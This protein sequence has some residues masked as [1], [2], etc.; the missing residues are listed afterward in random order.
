M[1]MLRGGRDGEEK[2]RTSKPLPY[3]KWM[4]FA[5]DQIEQKVLGRRTRVFDV[6]YN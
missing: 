5:E 4:C 3:N 2:S 6:P 1:D